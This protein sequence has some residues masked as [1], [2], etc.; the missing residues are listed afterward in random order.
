MDILNSLGINLGA[1][2]W[3]T[4]NFLILLF[5]IQ[6][7]L[8]KPVVRMLDERSNRIRE[9]LAHAEQVQAETARLE[10]ESKSILDEARRDGQQILAQANRT[11]EQ[12]MAE[13]RRQ[14]Q[15]EGERLI[16]RARDEIGRE[17]DQAFQELREQVA[18]LAV[19]AAGRVVQR[20]L[21]DTAHREL[22]RQFLADD[23]GDGA[24][25]G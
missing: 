23:T 13:A 3:H 15:S 14:A 4:V 10:A 1:V 9:S 8:Y 11:A 16:E 2:L 19:S 18:D 21:D 25:A 22:V 5:V 6:R 24:R 20:S 17:R 7:F 12:I